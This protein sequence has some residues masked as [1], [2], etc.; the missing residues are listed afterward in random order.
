MNWNAIGAIGEILGALVVVATVFY[1][2]VQIRHA[3][4]SNQ[5]VA[6][7]RTAE[8]S[9]GWARLL[10]EDVELLDV[11]LRGIKNFES[12]QRLERARFRLLITD[13]L[14]SVEGAWRQYELGA[15]TEDQWYGYAMSIRE[16]I[17]S[18]GGRVAYMKIKDIFNPGFC[19][20]IEQIISTDT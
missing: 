8:A 15:I 9:H 2:A 14:R 10:L 3:R 6:A 7:S 1:L 13:L 17:G 12:L 11:Y 19:G 5:I 20:A 4:D 16:I 18:P